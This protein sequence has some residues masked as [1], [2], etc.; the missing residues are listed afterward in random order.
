MLLDIHSLATLTKKLT[1][2]H[3]KDR[4]STC[5]CSKQ[6]LLVC[7][8]CSRVTCGCQRLATPLVPEGRCPC[9]EK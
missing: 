1:A 9:E 6:T 4:L 5:G 7:T 3:L 8:R 2:A